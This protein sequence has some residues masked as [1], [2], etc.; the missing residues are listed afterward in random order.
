M[1]ILV[2]YTGF[3]GSNLNEQIKFDG[4]FNSKNITEA[5]GL[6][7]DILYYAGVPAQKFIANSNP[8]ADEEVIQNAI[9]NIEMINPKKI[10]LISTID[11]YENPVDINEKDEVVV[12]KEAYG[13]N[14]YYLEEWVRDHFTDYLI[15]RLPALYGNNLKKN[16]IYDLVNYIPKL[17]SESKFQE[18]SE[19]DHKLNDY[20]SLNDNN[21]YQCKDL[22][23]EE[24]E[25]LKKVF[26][27]LG[28]SALNFTDSRGSYQFYNLGRLKKD[29]DTAL[30]NHIKVLNVAVEPVN[31]STLYEYL[32]HENFKNEL[33]KKVPSY[34]FKTV[35]DKLFGG[36]N[37]Y[38]VN[39]EEE[40]NDIKKFVLGE[41]K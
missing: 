14:R 5:Y 34:N 8:E 31:A 6:Q 21:F 22:T 10:V 12:S 27:R 17:L 39:K 33:N 32:Y 40:L 24:K 4:L 30:V 26:K 36:E 16:F 19:I 23:G 13:K 35:Y 18:L 37:G 38:I 29:I 3:V 9:H 20:Y 25:E 15:V 1:K 28:F 7:P 11:I 41:R 2:G